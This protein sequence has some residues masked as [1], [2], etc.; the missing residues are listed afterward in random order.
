MINADADSQHQQSKQEKKLSHTQKPFPNLEI[1]RDVVE[2]K[3][4]NQ[5]QWAN[6]QKRKD[7]IICRH[8]LQLTAECKY[9]NIVISDRHH[10]WHHLNQPKNYEQKH[11]PE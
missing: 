9:Q 4:P 8:K 2:L 5:N 7:V 3:Q 1:T 6:R 10:D 11:D